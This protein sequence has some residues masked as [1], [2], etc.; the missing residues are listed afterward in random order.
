MEALTSKSQISNSKFPRYHA[1]SYGARQINSNNQITTS[2]REKNNKEKKARLPEGIL[3]TSRAGKPCTTMCSSAIDVVQL[4]RVA[5]CNAVNKL[6]HGID[7]I[8]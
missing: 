2:K 4:F 6:I 8:K 3:G 1:G 5:F 7:I